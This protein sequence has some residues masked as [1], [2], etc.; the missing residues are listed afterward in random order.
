MPARFRNGGSLSLLKTSVTFTQCG[1]L[2]ELL[3]RHDEGHAV[4]ALLQLVL[5]RV[6][7]VVDQ[8]FVVVL[9]VAVLVHLGHD[10]EL[11]RMLEVEEQLDRLLASA[12]LTGSP[13]ITAESDVSRCWPSS[14]SRVLW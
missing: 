9:V 3:R 12:H 2:L 8:V 6:R 7:L 1:S 11:V 4:E 14:R 5:G 10:G 13:R